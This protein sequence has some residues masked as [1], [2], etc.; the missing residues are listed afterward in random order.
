SHLTNMQYYDSNTVAVWGQWTAVLLSNIISFSVG[1]FT[2]WSSLR[3]LIPFHPLYRPMTNAFSWVADV[4]RLPGSADTLR[5]AVGTTEFIAGMVC[6]VCGWIGDSLSEALVL[7]GLI[8]IMCVMSAASM[9]QMGRGVREI[10]PSMAFNSL[11]LTAI[12]IRLVAQWKSY[13]WWICT[14]TIIDFIIGILVLGWFV[15][16]RWSHDSTVVWSPLFG[17]EQEEVERGL[18]SDCRVALLARERRHFTP[19]ITPSSVAESDMEKVESGGNGASLARM[20]GAVM[21]HGGDYDNVGEANR[22]LQN[23]GNEGVV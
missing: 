8:A 22:V 17:P 9:T 1:S 13:P 15:Y 19:V 6:I 4:W 3:K 11:A 23:R 2:W 14:I 21:R 5:V 18:R 16:H 7:S 12:L 20:Q 10:L